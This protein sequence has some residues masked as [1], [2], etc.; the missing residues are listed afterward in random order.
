MRNPIFLASC[1][2]NFCLQNIQFGPIRWVHTRFFKISINHSQNLHLNLVFL[3]WAYVETIFSHT[4]HTEE[5]ISSH[6]ESTPNKFSCMLSQRKVFTVFTC[7][8]MLILRENDFIAPW[9]YEEMISLHPEQCCGSWSRIPNP[10][11]WNPSD[12]FLGKKFYNS[13]KIGPIFFLQHFKNKIIFSFVKFVATKK[14]LQQIFFRPSLLLL[15]L[16]PRSRI[17]DG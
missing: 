3:S 9:A 14:V 7:K 5:T 15:F 12:N 13:L 11:F 8:S 10:Y 6:T 17:R 16:D 4:E 1:K 2:K